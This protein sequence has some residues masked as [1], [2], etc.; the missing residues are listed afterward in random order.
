MDLLLGDWTATT[1]Q[2]LRTGLPVTF[3]MAGSP[4]KY[5]RGETEP[6]IVPGQV[7]NVPNYSVGPNLWPQ[8]NQNPF[9]NSRRFARLGALPRPT[10]TDHR[11]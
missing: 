6:N 9:F 1:I 8:S 7:I 5:L 2:S 11:P 4:Y 10:R 3:T